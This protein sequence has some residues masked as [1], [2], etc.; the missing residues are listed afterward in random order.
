M[1]CH[2]NGIIVQCTVAEMVLI[3]T[4]ASISFE[5]VSLF[6][7]FRYCSTSH[8][9][10]IQGLTWNS[11]DQLYTCGWDSKV[12]KHMIPDVSQSSSTEAGP[13][14]MEVNGEPTESVDTNDNKSVTK[15]CKVNGI[16]DSAD[17]NKNVEQET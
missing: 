6:L 1:N 7:F 4:H 16:G 17:V 11:E 10:F 9:D 14:K 8:V 13:T 2:H 15:K 3:S 12:L 5:Y